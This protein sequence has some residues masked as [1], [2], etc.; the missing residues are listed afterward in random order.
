MEKV[1]VM[2]GGNMEDA[3][4]VTERC[5]NGLDFIYVEV[6]Y[7]YGTFFDKKMKYNLLKDVCQF[8]QDLKCRYNCIRNIDAELNPLDIVDYFDPFN[9]VM[10]KDQKTQINELDFLIDR[11][12]LVSYTRSQYWDITFNWQCEA[13]SKFADTNNKRHSRLF[14]QYSAENPTY[15]KC[16]GTESVAENFLG[17][18]LDGTYAPPLGNMYK[19]EY[20]YLR[21]LEDA[22][23]ICPACACTTYTQNHY[24]TSS[25]IYGNQIMGSL[26]FTY[27]L[28]L[29]QYNTGL[30]P[31]QTIFKIA[32]NNLKE[33][34]LSISPNP[35]VNNL[36][37][38]NSGIAINKVS[39][40]DSNH[41]LILESKGNFENSL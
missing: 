6:E 8:G 7:W 26:W 22:N 9:P 30:P 2:M 23:Y 41:N 5:A 21:K 1:E 28:F 3:F 18:F 39:V 10:W 32:K 38:I 34:K 16:F 17:D 15:L 20:E 37:I 36:K 12:S 27:G 35:F 31:G 13:L 11:P 40:F 25:N 24:V 29:P 19:V 14:I 33:N 4:Q